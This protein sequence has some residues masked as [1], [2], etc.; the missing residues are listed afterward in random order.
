MA[1]CDNC[2]HVLH[3]TAKFCGGCGTVLDTPQTDNSQNQT[4]YAPPPQTN[5]APP[6]P[7]QTNYAP[8]PSLPKQKR[9]M[10]KAKKFGIGFCIFIVII[11]ALA[12]AVSPG[13]DSGPRAPGEMSESEKID[14]I[15][16]EFP[17]RIQQ[18]KR[19][20]LEDCKYNMAYLQ[21]EAVGDIYKERCIN[22]ILGR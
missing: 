9:S 3:P 12:V 1:F 17:E 14:Q 10:G 6:P 18:I 22:A 7:P 21:S 16:S 19:G 5:Y 13:S 2:G 20:Q 15:L 11:F 4:N 8:P